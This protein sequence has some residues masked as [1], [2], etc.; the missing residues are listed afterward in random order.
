MSRCQAT[1][2]TLILP[3]LRAARTDET[4]ARAP[5]GVLLGQSLLMFGQL[6]YLIV[7]HPWRTFV[8]TKERGP[9]PPL[10]GC[11]NRPQIGCDGFWNLTGLGRF[12]LETEEERPPL[13][14][15]A[16]CCDHRSCDYGK[17]MEGAF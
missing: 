17:K 16:H 3:C 9:A 6:A 8:A 12:E 15:S 10:R 1:A 4:A 13:S 14:G 5:T 2:Q 7:G 11:R